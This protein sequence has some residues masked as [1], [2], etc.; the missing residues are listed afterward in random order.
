M[1]AN[2]PKL[3]A[4]TRSLMANREIIAINQTASESHPILNLPAGFEYARVWEAQTPKGGRYLAFF[5]LEDK[6]TT[7]HAT[8]PQ[9]GLDGTHAAH[10]LW[11]G[12]QL[13]LS[14]T[15]EVLLAAHGSAVFQVE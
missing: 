9:L 13:K 5:N 14:A 12:K 7:L 1:G 3:D 2:L 10:S 15:I 8:W 4:F 11:G 6:P